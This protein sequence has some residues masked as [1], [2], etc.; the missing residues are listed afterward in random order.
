MTSS[1]DKSWGETDRSLNVH[2]DEG[3]DKP[4]PVALSYVIWKEKTNEEA[5]DT[6]LIVFTD[7]DFLSNAYIKQYSNAAM[8]LNAVNW[9]SDLD[10]RVF[11]D[12]K[13]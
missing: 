2:F 5:T 6:R 8:G 3:I 4:G 1:K 11:I 9:V 13:T 12:E 7:A 10:Y